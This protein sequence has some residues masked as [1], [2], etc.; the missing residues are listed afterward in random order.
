M[1]IR[2]LKEATHLSSRGERVFS[3]GLAGRKEEASAEGR[4]RNRAS[5]STVITAR[6]SEGDSCWSPTDSAMK[7]ELLVQ[8][9]WALSL[10]SNNNNTKNTNNTQL[11]V[12]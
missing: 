2:L 6:E 3:S 5:S 10:T 7:R 4:G 11:R 12:W 8:H 9:N 1:F